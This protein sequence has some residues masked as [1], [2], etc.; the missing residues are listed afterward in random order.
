M[1][2]VTIKTADGT[3]HT[4]EIVKP[5]KGRAEI[6]GTYYFIDGYGYICS[7]TESGD[8]I[9]DFCWGS[10]NYFLTEEE[11]EAKQQ[12]D[13]ALTTVRRRIQELNGDW[14]ADCSDDVQHK[15][16]IFYENIKREWVVTYCTYSQYLL[17]Y[18][19]MASKE[20]AKTIIREYGDTLLPIIR[21]YAI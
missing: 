9:D 8:K 1:T 18:P 7:Q 3:L 6:A 21:D 14:K 19:F 12:Y 16:H 13:I 20:V 4:G 15:W 11:A 5:Q 10:G 2:K 17:P